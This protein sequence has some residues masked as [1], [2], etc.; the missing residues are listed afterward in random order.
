MNKLRRRSDRIRWAIS[1]RG[2][3]FKKVAEK[4]H[5]STSTL[6]SYCQRD[7]TLKDLDIIKKLGDVTGVSWIWIACGLGT[8][9]HIWLE[10]TQEEVVI[11]Q[12]LESMTEKERHHFYHFMLAYK[13]S[14][15][16]RL[17]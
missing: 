8:P 13:E 3:G 4:M 11:R 1:R 9:D 10:P 6:Y 16:S 2:G 12:T 14:D 15:H 7:S 5:R 17:L